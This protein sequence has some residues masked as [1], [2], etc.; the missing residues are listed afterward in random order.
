MLCIFSLSSINAQTDQGKILLGTSTSIGFWGSTSEF[1]NLGFTSMKYKSDDYDDE[2]PDKQLSFNLQPKFGFLV[3][4]NFAIGLDLLVYLQTYKEGGSDD[5]SISTLLLAGPFV[6]YYIPTG[7][8]KPF[9]EAAGSYGGVFSKSEYS[10]NESTNTER[11]ISATGRAGI[12][13]PLGDVVLFETSIYYNYLNMK[14]TEDND[15]N[16]RTIYNTF[17]VNIGFIILL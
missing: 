3:A 5:K 8:V 7:N 6:R 15:P 1:M 13:I 11:V 16:Y 4:D 12:A 2:D 17:G 14:D 10:G 9:I